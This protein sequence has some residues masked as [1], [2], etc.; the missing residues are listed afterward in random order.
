MNQCNKLNS[1][2]PLS[3]ITMVPANDFK[4][5]GFVYFMVI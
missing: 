3:N 5:I 1:F 2:K 4:P